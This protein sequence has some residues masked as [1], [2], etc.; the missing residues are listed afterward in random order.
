MKGKSE[1]RTAILAKVD[2]LYG[3][4]IFRGKFLEH[5][6]LDKDKDKLIKNFKTSSISNE[7][8]TFEDNE[9]LNSICENI[10]EKLSQKINKIKS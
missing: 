4:C 9:E 3:I 10:L 7:V 1:K 6:F 2:F 5:L 8:N